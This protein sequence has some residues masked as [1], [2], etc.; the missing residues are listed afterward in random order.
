[1]AGGPQM[2]TS[3]LPQSAWRGTTAGSIPRSPPKPGSCETT[4]VTVSCGHAACSL[5]RSAMSYRP[6]ACRAPTN[7]LIRLPAWAA[8]APSM[9]A[10]SGARPVPPATHTRLRPP[11]SAAGSVISPRAGPSTRVSPGLA[12]WTRALLTMPPGPPWHLDGQVLARQVP[13]RRIGP[14]AH[15]RDIGAALLMAHDLGGPPGRPVPGVVGCGARHRA[16]R[17]AQEVPPGRLALGRPVRAVGLAD[18]SQ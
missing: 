11:C 15:H 17:E 8:I 10:F 12:W 5:P 2:S 6:A 18:R 3:L 7:R 14:D 13:E 4:G 16:L 1:M 9:I